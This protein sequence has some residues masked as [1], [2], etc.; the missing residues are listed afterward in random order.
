MS[1]E[2]EACIDPK[3][4][5]VEIP[6][7]TLA[8]VVGTY[9][10]RENLKMYLNSFATEVQFF[11][12]L[13]FGWGQAGQRMASSPGEVPPT[14]VYAWALL[15]CLSSCKWHHSQSIHRNSW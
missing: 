4:L 3:G 7:E 9:G 13:I 8:A 10:V 2:T 5:I 15:P 6:L 1:F 14:L 11:S 12:R